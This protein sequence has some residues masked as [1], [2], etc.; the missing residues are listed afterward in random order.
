MSKDFSHYALDCMGPTGIQLH[1]YVISVQ[2]LGVLKRKIFGKESTCSKEKIR[3]FHRW[4]TVR[5]KLE[6]ILENKVVQK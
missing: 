2:K 1:I 3:K 6:M 5:Q 4:M